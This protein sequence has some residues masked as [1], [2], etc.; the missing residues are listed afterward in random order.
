MATPDGGIVP[1]EAR[2]L[3]AEEGY[4]V[5]KGVV[6]K[7]VLRM[8][9]EECSY[10]LGYMDARID[11]G[12]VANEALSLPRQALFREQPLPFQPA[13]LALRLWRS[14]GGGMPRHAWERGVSLQR[15]MGRQGCGT[16]H[17]VLL[18]PGTPAYVKFMDPETVHE[19]YLTCWCALD[20]V[21]ETNGTVYLLPHSRAGT[22]GRIITH[23]RDAVSHDLIGYTGDD[24]GVALDVPAG[25][26]VAFLEL[27]PASQR[28]EYHGPDASCLPNAIRV[29]TGL[30]FPNRRTLQPRRGVPE[31]RTER[32]RPRHGIRRNDGVGQPRRRLW[33]RDRVDHAGRSSRRVVDNH[34]LI[35]GERMQDGLLAVGPVDGQRIDRVGRP[36]SE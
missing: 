18:A 22:K 25:S 36:Q 27:Q 9:R 28:R 1:G 26:I 23:S 3:Y 2:Q 4:M 24:P 16:G 12:L 11:A 14:H 33:S 29:G 7:D 32:L 30:A 17:E 10:F 20:D 8:L 5:L 6:P 19:P 31:G 21:D 35:G 34:L 15:T 13:P